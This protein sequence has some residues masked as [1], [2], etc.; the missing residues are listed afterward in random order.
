MFQ[1]A[2]SRSLAAICSLVV[3]LAVFGCAEGSISEADDPT[4]DSFALS[5]QWVRCATQG[6]YCAFD[7][8]R[9]VRYG[10][11]N[12]Y[13]L[14]TF[15]GGVSCD[16]ALFGTTRR[17]SAVCDFDAKSGA[18]GAGAAGAGAAGSI[19][20][21]K[22]GSGGSGSVAGSIS[23]PKAGSGGS[24]S[25]AG[26][27]SPPKAGSGGSGSAAGSISPPTAGSGG[28]GSAAGSISP[29]TA[30]SGG[31]AGTLP[32][33]TPPTAAGWP[34]AHG[35]SGA[36]GDPVIDRASV[37]AFCTWRGRPC[38]IAHVYTER[39]SWD[40]MTRGTGWS[41]DN[42]AGF[43]GQLIVSQGLVPNGGSGDLASCASG[44]HDQDFRDF[45]TLMV[46]KG[47]GASVVRL[48]WEFNGTFMPWGATNTDVWKQCFQHAAAA[49]RATNPSVIVDWTIN[50]HGTPS[51][52]CGGSSINCYPGDAWVD[53]IGIDNYDLAPSS[54][55][56]A[57]FKR[58]AEAPDGLT[59]IYNFAKQHNKP[60]SVGEWGVAPGS[61]W[62]TTG[63]NAEFVRWMHDWFA[64]HAADIAYEMYFNDCSAG[65]VESN[66]YRPAGSN[67]VR[68][69]V[70]AGDVYKSLF[71]G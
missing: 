58:I 20:V 71:G 9:Q 60:L 62:N 37:E 61:D 8:T 29:P 59:W 46:N 66:L 13:T 4:A 21:P 52:V 3:S 26:S 31:G 39:S 16:A 69:N 12:R 32:P 35:K 56:A 17:T 53:I 65:E 38:A 40:K 2:V 24:G 10:S 15:S 22:A 43:P 19:S 68:R 45:G 54:T 63:E 25:A 42:F 50:A 1:H 36:N 64:A 7:G 67:C 28:S 30:G 11:R 6:G 27:I 70:A 47:R 57:D 33:V 14:K 23:V 41:F 5:R 18:A 48:G 34:G 44:A 55:S 49:I 51:N